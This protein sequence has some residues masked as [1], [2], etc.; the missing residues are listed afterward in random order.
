MRDANGNVETVDNTFKRIYT[1]SKRVVW[2]SRC[3]RTSVDYI[4]R[5]IEDFYS[6]V[7][8]ENLKA[9]YE[10]QVT[11]MDPVSGHL[12]SD[13]VYMYP[14]F[15]QVLPFFLQTGHVP[16]YIRLAMESFGIDD[17]D[18]VPSPDQVPDFLQMKSNAEKIYKDTH[19]R[20]FVNAYRDGQLAVTN[21]KL[22]KIIRKYQL[23][24]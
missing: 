14:D 9:M 5:R 23:N 1:T 3:L 16:K 8:Y 22:H 24:L 20:Q 4:V 15:L 12:L 19:K 17:V 7:D 2:F 18:G 10:K 6:K 11:Y 21:P 13:L